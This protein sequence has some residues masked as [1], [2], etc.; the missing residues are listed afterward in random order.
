M[1]ANPSRSTDTMRQ[2]CGGNLMFNMY[3]SGTL[4]LLYKTG[5]S[6]S[7]L[8]YFRGQFLPFSDAGLL[9]GT[10][11]LAFQSETRLFFCR[12]SDFLFPERVSWL[13]SSSSGKATEATR[14]PRLSK[15]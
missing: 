12:K 6:G 13:H 7:Y 5:I 4:A 10:D 2:N 9:L 14:E 11:C 3:L 15:T 1:K 8:L